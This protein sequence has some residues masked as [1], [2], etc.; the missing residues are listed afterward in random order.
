MKVHYVTPDQMEQALKSKLSDEGDKKQIEAYFQKKK[1]NR[2]SSMW[3]RVNK[4]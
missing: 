1:K 3:K 2:I 4:K